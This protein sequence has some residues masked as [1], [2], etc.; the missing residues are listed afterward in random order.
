MLKIIFFIAG[1]DI[2]EIKDLTDPVDAR[3]K[4]SMGQDVFNVLEN[5]PFPTIAAIRGACLGGGLELALACTYRV[6]SDHPKTVLG[7]PEVTLGIVPGFG[8]TQ[9][10]PRL[11]GLEEGLNLILKGKFVA[12]RAAYRSKL[13]DMY[14]S[15]EFWDERLKAFVQ[16]VRNP[17]QAKGLRVNRE[18]RPLRRKIIEDFS[19]AR[20][21]VFKKSRQ[22]LLKQTKGNYPA[23]L[24]ALDVIEQTWGVPL[25]EGLRKEADAFSVLPGDPVCQNLIGLFYTREALKKKSGSNNN[26]NATRN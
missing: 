5:L 9:R 23:P 25:Q 4:A 26:R 8:G 24:A 20:K 3:S 21:Y 11:V 16:R 7:L 2:A 19:V 6:A 10:L 13:I 18:A 17:K 15:D 14:Y 22:M 1:A 12:P